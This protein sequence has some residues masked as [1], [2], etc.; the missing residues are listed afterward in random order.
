MLYDQNWDSPKET[1][2]DIKLEPWQDILLKAADIL[3]TKG[4]TQ[5]SYHDHRGFCAVGAIREAVGSNFDSMTNTQY[6]LIHKAANKFRTVIGT[7]DITVWNDARTT[8]KQT[9]IKTLKRAA[10]VV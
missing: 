2:P 10:N 1:I 6:D 7:H 8:T 4:W 9:V 3:E 5:Y